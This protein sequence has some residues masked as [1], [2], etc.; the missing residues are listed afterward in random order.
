MR[1]ELKIG[2]VVGLIIAAVAVLYVVFHDS[3]PPQPLGA[4]Q[5]GPAPPPVVPPA[6]PVAPGEGET[7]VPTFARAPAPRPGLVEVTPEIAELAPAA[8]TTAE[9]VAPE[10]TRAEGPLAVRIAP[11]PATQPVIAPVT[12]PVGL[13]AR[14][15]G[16]TTYVVKL[17]DQG[18]WDIAEKVYGPGKGKYWTLIAKANPQVE[19]TRLKEGMRLTIPPL[20]GE[21]TAP[22]PV[23]MPL[24]STEERV[25][26]VQPDDG[27]WIISRKVYGDGR[28][29]REL[30]QA[31]PHV[32]GTLKAGQKIR[33]PPL[34]SLRSTPLSAPAPAP[35]SPPPP[36]DDRPMFD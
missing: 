34:D 7:L 27:W 18:F 9:P 11:S 12:P 1:A 33:I 36:S 20:G 35:A 5:A 13:A 30:R 8:G 26:T 17:G 24:P 22:S 19:S 21:P 29:W 31:N 6:R 3:G 4:P 23:A 25:Y 32:E 28:Y 2:I 15:G 16:T 10:A 14:P